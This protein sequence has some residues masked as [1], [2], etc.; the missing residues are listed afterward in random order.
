MNIS[1]SEPIDSNITSGENK[2]FWTALTEPI[3]FEKK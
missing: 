2:S 3:I 1:A